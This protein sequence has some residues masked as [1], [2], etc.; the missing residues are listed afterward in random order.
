MRGG[1]LGKADAVVKA[2]PTTASYDGN[3][4]LEAPEE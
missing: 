3:V 1:E 4:M 2:G